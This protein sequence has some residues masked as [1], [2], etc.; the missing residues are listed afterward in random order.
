MPPSGKSVALRER[1]GSAREVA[2]AEQRRDAS[3]VG[4]EGQRRQIA[5]QLDV[6]VELLRNA[7]RQ[8][9]DFGNVAGGFRRQLNAAAR[10]RGSRRCTD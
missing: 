10:S 1:I 2:R 6:I 9:R 3:D 8:I 5:V 7:G 4:L